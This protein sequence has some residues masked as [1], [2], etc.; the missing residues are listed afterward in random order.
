MCAKFDGVMTAIIVCLQVKWIEEQD[1]PF[2]LVVRQLNLFELSINNSHAAEIRCPLL[3]LGAPQ[4][5]H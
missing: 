2:A 5:I 1:E 4:I 3:N